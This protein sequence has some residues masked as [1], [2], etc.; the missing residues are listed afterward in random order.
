MQIGKITI[1]WARMKTK[2][3]FRFIINSFY[4]TFFSL[5]FSQNTL[6]VSL[7]VGPPLE[8][9]FYVQII[10]YHMPTANTLSSFGRNQTTQCRI[11]AIQNLHFWAVFGVALV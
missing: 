3:I 5:L 10:F 2:F 9:P 6:P 7:E 8:S 4:W 11:A 1:T